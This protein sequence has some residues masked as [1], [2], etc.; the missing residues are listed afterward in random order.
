MLLRPPILLALCMLLLTLIGAAPAFAQQVAVVVS[1]RG[2]A[3]TELAEAFDRQLK[4]HYPKLV[5]RTVTAGEYDRQAIRPQLILTVGTQAAKAVSGAAPVP[6]I[7]TLI[8]RSTFEAVI[9]PKESKATAVFIDQPPSR[10]IELVR[11]ALPDFHRVALIAGDDSAELVSRL[12]D[13]ARAAHLT[14]EREDVQTDQELYGALQKVFAEPAALIATPDNSIFNSYSIQNVLLTAY[15][16]HS[17]LVGFSAAYVRAGALVAVYSTPAQMARQAAE[18][19][20]TILG[21]GPLPPAQP[22]RYFEVATNPNVARS[23]GISLD[24]PEALRLKIQH[25]EA[26]AP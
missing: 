3:Y 2:G 1:Y 5:L 20:Q 15:R 11:Q 9:A 13:A 18:M 16:D 7:H 26:G 17:P 6:V 21:G 4:R 12:A 23:M 10:Q 25:T 19:A 22:P 24:D 14:V 8:P